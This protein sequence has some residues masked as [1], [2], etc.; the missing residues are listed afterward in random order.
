[1]T[2]VKARRETCWHENLGYRQEFLRQAC[3]AR[4]KVGEPKPILKARVKLQDSEARMK[5]RHEG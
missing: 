3:K 5:G 4:D 1:M 2:S